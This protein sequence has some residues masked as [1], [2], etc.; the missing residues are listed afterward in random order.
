MSFH[1]LIQRL[2]IVVP[3]VVDAF[4]IA[5][6]ALAAALATAVA[7]S[8]AAAVA[9]AAVVTDDESFIIAVALPVACC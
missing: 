9:D 2:L 8:V 6:A 3:L 7:A 4:I 5:A 1:L